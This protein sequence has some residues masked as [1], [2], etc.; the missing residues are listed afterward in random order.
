MRNKCER[1]LEVKGRYTSGKWQLA[2]FVI[3][4]GTVALFLGRVTGTEYTAVVSLALTI[5]SGANV[6]Q[7]AVQKTDDESNKAG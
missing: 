1:G 3:V 5:Y 4:V 2:A 7:K 6:A